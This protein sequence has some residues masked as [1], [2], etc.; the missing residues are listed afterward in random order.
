[1]TSSPPQGALLEHPD[2]QER[3]AREIQEVLASRPFAS[4][5]VITSDLHTDTVESRTGLYRATG[6]GKTRRRQRAFA[7]HLRRLGRRYPKVKYP[8]VVVLID[9]APGTRASRSTGLGR[10]P[11]PRVEAAAQLQPAVERDRA[12]RE[13]AAAAGDP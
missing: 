8:R 4:V 1:M 9:N 12:L 5:N 3:V 6:E 2:D 7:A 11:E 10:P 13:G